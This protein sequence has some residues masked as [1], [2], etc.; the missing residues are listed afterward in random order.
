MKVIFLQDVAHVAKKGEIKDVNDGYARNYLIPL[1]IAVQS[2]SAV[3]LKVRKEQ[4]HATAKRM[5]KED[6]LREK[7]KQINGKSLTFQLKASKTGT[8]F[9]GLTKEQVLSRLVKEYSIDP[10]VI[11]VDLEKSLKHVGEYPVPIE[12]NSQKASIKVVITNPHE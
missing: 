5:V 8:T 2:S 4:D 12:I 9:S 10:T 6:V 11:T 7:V 3:E 1:N